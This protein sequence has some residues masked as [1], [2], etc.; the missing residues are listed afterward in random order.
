[1]TDKEIVDRMWKRDEAALDAA[2]EK[3]EKNCLHISKNI[4]GNSEDAEEC[5]NDAFLLLWDSVPPNRPESLTAYLF[6]IVRNLSLNK[7][8]YNQRQKRDAH[9]D[10][11]YDELDNL[12][13]DN[14]TMN[15]D[16]ETVRETINAF[17][18]SLPR[19]DA[20]LFVRRYW[21]MDTVESLALMF[22]YSQK[23]V[24]RK[25]AA[26][27]EALRRDLHEKGIIR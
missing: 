18:N 4:L 25:L 24:Y 5:V 17:L 21:Y 23:K 15:A 20:V 3:Y 8:K 6:R 11:P 13:A 7:S 2:H 10:T 22:G 14:E 19:E 12:I 1:M 27:R 26:L 9:A 16:G